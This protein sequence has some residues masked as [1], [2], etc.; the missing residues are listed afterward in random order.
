MRGQEVRPGRQWRRRGSPRE[1]SPRAPAA[2]LRS[3]AA[4]ADRHRRRTPGS[5]RAEYAPPISAWTVGWIASRGDA[6]KRAQLVAPR[7]GT[8]EMTSPAGAAYLTT[9]MGRDYR[10]LLLARL[11]RSFC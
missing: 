6:A 4:R 9:A 7:G 11:L 5:P 10:L 8:P 2:V 3:S 1:S